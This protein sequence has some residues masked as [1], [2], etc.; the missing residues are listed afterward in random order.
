MQSAHI[1]FPDSRLYDTLREVFK[2]EEFR[3]SQKE[4]ITRTLAGGHSLVLM[5]TGMGKSLL[6]QLPA[7]LMDG[8]TVVISPLIALMKDQVDGLCRLGV[9]AAFINS[10]L[11]KSER[12]ARYRGLREGKYKILYV[13][14]ERFRNRDFVGAL[15]GR[16]VS[17]LALD[18]AHCVSRW[19]N[20]FRP[21]YSRVG[22]FREAMGNPVT[23]A[24]T[25][26]ATP[27]VRND[28]V[29]KLGISNDDIRVFNEGVT[30]PNLSLEV[31]EFIDE[32][33]KFE[34]LNGLIEG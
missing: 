6:Y 16:M 18:E 34:A 2:V 27:E 21:D 23:I 29:D 28:I 8:L 19:G 32:G 13:S 26:T 12:E 15:G 11:G 31:D 20:D 7:L 25:A 33:E 17:L 22:E 10:S 30:R 3:S 9:D 5:P 24:L 1:P 14:P 4:I